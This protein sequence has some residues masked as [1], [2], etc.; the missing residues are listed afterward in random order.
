M[1]SARDALNDLKWHR[2]S[3]EGV[4]VAYVHRG[5]PD[6]TAYAKGSDILAVRRSF[7]DLAGGASIPYHR[8]LRITVAGETIW[9][10]RGSS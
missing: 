10:R 4:E 3:L 9:Q 7:F 5:A 6:D 8:V 1:T 2:G